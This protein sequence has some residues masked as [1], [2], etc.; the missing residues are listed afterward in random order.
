MPTSVTDINLNFVILL[1]FNRFCHAIYTTKTYFAARA[2]HVPSAS[3]VLT[4]TKCVIY[5]LYLHLCA[6][7]IPYP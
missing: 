7:N 4:F 6:T 1:A 2:I 5:F 3:S